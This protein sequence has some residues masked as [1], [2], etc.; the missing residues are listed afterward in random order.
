MLRK[1]RRYF[2]CCMV[3]LSSLV[4][5]AGCSREDIRAV[6]DLI[7]LHEQLSA[8]YGESNARVEIQQGNTL[9]ITFVNSSFNDLTWDHKTLQ[10]QEI[11]SFVC[12]NYASMDRI[13][14]VLV[15]LETY[16]DSFMVDATSSVTFAFEKNELECGNS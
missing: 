11:A 9:G 1:H 8:E 5:L 6:R 15:T 12:E 13:D 2:S 3:A 14:K 7:A 10:A 4:L 16:R